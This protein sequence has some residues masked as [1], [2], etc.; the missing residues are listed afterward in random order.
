MKCYLILLSLL[1]TVNVNAQIGKLY[2]GDNQLS[3]SFV[4]NVF[5][6]K[7]GYMWIA[8]RNG[9][10]R[11]DGY[12][13]KI[14]KKENKVF[15][16]TSN[17]IN[18][19]YQDRQG[20]LFIGTNNGVQ[21]MVNGKFEDIPLLRAND[22][23]IKT[24]ITGIL[25]LKNGDIIVSSSGYGVMKLK[26]NYGTPYARIP[27]NTNYV[28]HMLEDKHGQLWL[29]TED[30]GLLC[31]KG[32]RIQRYFFSPE[33]IACIKDG[34]I[35]EDKKG[36][37]YVGTNG[38][39]L[40]KLSNGAKQF[41]Q[42]KSTAKMPIKDL[43]IDH[44][45]NVL[46]GCD[47]I[48]LYVYYPNTGQLS[49]NP[50]YSND[51]SLSKTK[52][53]TIVED[54]NGNI[55]LGMMQKGV[56]MQPAKRRNFGYMGPKLG[57]FNYIGTNCVTSIIQDT[58]RRLWVGTDKDGLYLLDSNKKLIRHYTNVP[59]T[60]LCMSEDKFGR[61]WI[62]SYQQGCGWVDGESAAYHAVDI[63]AGG[64]SSIFGMDVDKSGN[65]WFG[66]MGQGLIRLN[67]T[68]YSITQYRMKA[69][70]DL[71]RHINSLPNDY[72]A[73]IKVSHDGTK[74][75]VAS[76]VGMSCLDIK[77]SSWL[78]VFGSNC[79]NYATF[80]R[81]VCED[82]E[83]HIWM[84][85]NDGL[86]C[87]NLKSRQSKM[88]TMQNGLPDNG[89][90]S[91]E[92]DKKGRLWIG[93]DHGL[94]CMTTDGKVISCYYANNGLQSNEF[95]DGASF[96]C[97]D[98]HTMYFGGT[99]GINWFDAGK[100]NNMPWKANV[101]IT[102]II[103]GNKERNTDIT[104]D[105]FNLEYEDN[106]FSIHLSTL[107]Y[108]DPNNITYLYSINGEEWTR[109]QPGMNEIT[110]SHLS[111]GTYKFRVK[112]M[113]NNMSSQIKE[114]TMHISSPWYSSTVAYI[115]Y[116]IIIGVIIYFI[117]H[118]QKRK[119]YDRMQIQEHIHAEQMG[120]AKLKFF[121]NISH[122]IRTP[123]TLIVSP[124]LQLIKEDDDMHRRSVYETIKRN[125]ERILHLI[126]QMMD[127]RKIDKGMLTMHMQETDMVNFID[128]VYS[129]FSDQAKIKDID[130]NFTHDSDT[131]PLWIDR[132]NFDKVLVNIISNAFKF[133]PTGGKID[134]ELTHNDS[135]ANITI[136]D[137]GE[138]IPEE[139]IK[140]IFER[141][142]QAQNSVND[143]NMGTG[144]GLDLARSLVELHYGDI[145]A[146]N[147]ENGDGC[148]FIVTLPLGNSH[149]KP[150]E[151]VTEEDDN[152][153]IDLIELNE[154]N[155]A[156]AVEDNKMSPDKIDIL[157]EQLSNRKRQTIVIAE[158]DD[159]IRQYLEREL[160]G[161]FYVIAC[162][163]GKEALTAIMKEIPSL[164]ISDVMMPVMDGNELCSRV[165]SNINTNHI[166]VIMLTA[167]SRD[168]DRLEG[169]EMGADTYIVKPFNLDILR[170]TIINLLHQRELLRNKFNG[171]E[172]QENN[173]EKINV[174][175]P[176]NKLLNRIMSVINNNLSDPSLNV[177]MIAQEVGISRVHLHRKM[178]ELTNQTPHDFIRNLRLKQAAHLLEQGY[179]NITEV[180]F[181]CGFTN[182]AS[183]STMFKN[184]YGRSPRE[185]M[186]N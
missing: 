35:R 150:E 138:K 71:N 184:L 163:N 4:N 68:D 79:P 85:T 12:Q 102:G 162:P 176:D 61:I 115:L 177:D 159:E 113:Y 54:R 19:V 26:G 181:A 158:D 24:Y 40:W 33:E 36:N 75:Y 112:A 136:R 104:G 128:D 127:L 9:L 178:K 180:M 29:V 147:I 25:Q 151:M 52:I 64:S 13:F 122:D 22:K 185:Y 87:Y 70:A 120:E 154:E 18:C 101:I 124:L 153:K 140:R 39:G 99:D 170:R 98:G 156:P 135:E 97:K 142:Y 30:K 37:I 179:Q 84:G 15:G 28:V 160:S 149:L 32:K 7:D 44:Q 72:L 117:Y 94:C 81:I 109:L 121:M 42:I 53:Q 8:T 173:L 74:I 141:F 16:I 77:S 67:L 164:I 50:F 14:L 108:D 130:F 107:T 23:R 20:T 106:S 10:N 38:M 90:A 47:G 132:H 41:A 134:I 46:L 182:P 43:Y 126:N 73:K 82:H 165:K 118:Y 144:I 65:I 129:L 174:E 63:K 66:T 110:F 17:Y 92:Q 103:I 60:I 27:K 111:S 58:R 91:I 56:F 105:N 133:T 145:Q 161:D 139:N 45:G 78:S 11:Y 34:D 1:F 3:S 69:G 183:F 2:N 96:I 49:A 152:K 166:P 88:Y 93:T 55:W 186:K 171:S 31:F 5:Q 125:A 57:T 80:S 51:I 137:N 148:E 21:K 48:G 155:D 6:D 62:G 175:S 119:E 168:E 123:M 83:G 167:K 169:L 76:S 59:G 86:Y 100:T 95:S 89:I 114:F 116:L 157:N 172:S 146:H 143:N 131:L